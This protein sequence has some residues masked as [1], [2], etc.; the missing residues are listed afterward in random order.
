MAQGN[1]KVSF[2]LNVKC[3]NVVPE[4][5]PGTPWVAER[6]DGEIFVLCPQNYCSDS[7][8]LRDGYSWELEGSLLN[9]CKMCREELEDVE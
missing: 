5:D 9:E 7:I 1:H 2:L 6:I 4:P 8:G 3:T